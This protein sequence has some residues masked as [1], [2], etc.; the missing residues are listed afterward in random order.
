MFFSSYILFSIFKKIAQR[1]KIH[2][3]HSNLALSVHLDP[4]MAFQTLEPPHDWRWFQKTV[5]PHKDMET[6]GSGDF[7][8]GST[9]CCSGL[10]RKRTNIKK[11]LEGDSISYEMCR[12][13]HYS[14]KHI[15]IKLYQLIANSDISSSGALHNVE[16]GCSFGVVPPMVAPSIHFGTD[17]AHCFFVWLTSTILTVL[18]TPK[19]NWSFL[20]PRKTYRD[21]IENDYI[22]MAIWC[23]QQRTEQE[24]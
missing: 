17:T 1:L 2:S 23:H 18:S 15:T 7:P 21:A 22:F 3:I 13:M 16:K 6:P 4:S 8:R 24:A 5:A 9:S 20:C 14:G 11:F 12:S 10:W 19:K